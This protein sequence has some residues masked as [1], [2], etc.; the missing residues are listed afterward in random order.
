MSNPSFYAAYLQRIKDLSKE[1][2]IDMAYGTLP[3]HA[4]YKE[5]CGIIKGLDRAYGE[6][7][8]M[9]KQQLKEE[10]QQYD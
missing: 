7:E 8:D 3:D 9:V 1:L 5:A 6:F 10:E 2:A 4:A